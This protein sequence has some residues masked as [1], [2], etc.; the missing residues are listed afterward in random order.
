MDGDDKFELLVWWR[1]KIPQ[2]I[3][4]V[5]IMASKNAFSIGGRVLDSFRSYFSP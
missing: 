2:A 1:K 3:K 4:H 5:S